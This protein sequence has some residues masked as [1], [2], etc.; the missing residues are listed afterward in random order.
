L[1]EIQ[2]GWPQLASRAGAVSSSLKSLQQQQQR[3]GFG[4]RGDMASSWKRM[5][6]Y[7]DQAE[8]AVSAKD[9]DAAK[10][11]VENAEREI[12]ILEKF[13]GR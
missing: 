3:S 13:L 12:A 7:M 4:L 9:A 11:N 1:K 8:A 6:Y 5:E 2:R 10:E